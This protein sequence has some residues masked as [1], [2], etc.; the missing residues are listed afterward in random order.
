[1]DFLPAETTSPAETM[2][3]GAR[4]AERL[5]PGDVVALYGDLG[6]GKTHLAKGL[7]A[8]LGVPEADVNSPTFT[9]VNE[10]D[11]SAFPI[12]HFDAYRIRHADEFFELGFEDYFYGRG[13]CLV[14]WP[15]RIEALLPPATLRLRL[16]HVDEHRRRIEQLE[17]VA[18]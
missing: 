15:E 9:I 11:G 14:E 12:Y 2:A 5:R 7:C 4:L 3:L 6:A 13:L 1:M 16:S 8:A 10:Y 18:A 17:D